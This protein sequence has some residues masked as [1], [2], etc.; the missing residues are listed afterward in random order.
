MARPTSSA[1][2]EIARDGDDVVVYPAFV[3]AEEG[4]RGHQGRPQGDDDATTETQEVGTGDD[5][6]RAEDLDGSERQG[7]RGHRIGE[8]CD[9]EGDR[10]A[11]A[12]VTLQADW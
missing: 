8:G 2:G 5:Q 7:E 1:D 9:D 10:E 12:Q 11:S 3:D 4:D 6:G